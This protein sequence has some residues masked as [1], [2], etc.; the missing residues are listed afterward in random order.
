MLF[1][2]SQ[3]HGHDVWRASRAALR[4]VSAPPTADGV[5]TTEPGVVC[6]VMVA[7]CLPVLVADR[8]GRAVGA[9]H[10]GWRGLAGAG[11]MAGQ[12]ILETGVAHMLAATG[13]QASDLLAWLGPCIGPTSFQV[14]ADVLRG[15]G[16]E[17]A[18]L[19][20]TGFRV[21]PACA[22]G[23][24][25]WLADLPALAAQRLRALGVGQIR[26][27]GLCTVSSPDRFFSYRRDG[28]TG[29]QAAL[30]ALAPAA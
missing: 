8:F 11:D 1:R 9:F 14:G 19:A 13:G 6:A 26:A 21:D 17:P 20:G 16:V 3:V 18:A 5:I 27:S 29:R 7:D 12:G 22:V 24:P 25:K 23:A 30:I 10:A 28:Q 15:F 2:S 4:N